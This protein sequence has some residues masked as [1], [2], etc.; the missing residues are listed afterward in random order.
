MALSD[1]VRST[2]AEVARRARRVSIDLEAL[3]RVQPGEPGGLDPDR[4]FLEGDSEAVTMYLLS[5]SAVNFGSGWFPQ[6]RKRALNGGTVSGYLT[7]AWALADRFRSEGPW[8]PAALRVMTTSEAAALLGQRADLELMALYAQA[9][10][11]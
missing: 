2:C 10:R 8:T 4:H 11:G 6:L 3:G 1:E 7:V 9:L 5:L